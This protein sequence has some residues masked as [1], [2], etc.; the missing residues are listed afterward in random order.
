MASTNNTVIDSGIITATFTDLD[1]NVFS[2]F[3]INPTDIR[4]GE[5]AIASAEFFQTIKAESFDVDTVGQLQKDIE[6]KISYILGYDSSKDIFGEVSALTVLP[7]G[8]FFVEIIVD[9]IMEIVQPAVKARQEAM[10]KRA[11]KYTKKYEE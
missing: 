9:K 3:R 8:R 1:G 2:K 11:D 6:D 10:A 4:T 5:R 7:D